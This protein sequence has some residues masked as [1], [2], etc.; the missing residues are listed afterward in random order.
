MQVRFIFNL[1]Q[2]DELFFGYNVN[3]T[4]N[5]IEQHRFNMIEQQIRTWEVLDP[6]VLNLLHQVPREKFVPT[7]YQGVAFADTEIPL[8]EDVCMLAPKLEARLIQSSSLQK[9]DHVLVVGSGSGY[10]SALTASLVKSV[11]S[12]DINPYFT[13]LAKQNCQNIKL[14]NIEFVTGDGSLGWLKNQ[15]YDAI[16]F[17]GSLPHLPVS[18][19]NQLNVNGRLLAILGEAPS[20]HATLITRLNDQDFEEE[21]LFE[22]V[23][24]SLQVKH[25]NTF[26]F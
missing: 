10:L 14:N 2:N 25:E 23:V 26:V 4:I 7:E 12:V 22:T 21:I 18:I 24:P 17:A 19:R 6:E 11:V 8:Y 9:K 16:L 3:M 15:P 13:K 1:Y 5:A 20:M